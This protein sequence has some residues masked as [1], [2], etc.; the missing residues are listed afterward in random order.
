MGFI[1]VRA[2]KGPRHEFDAPEAVVA[3]SPSAYVVLDRDPVTEARP[4]RYVTRTAPE[5]RGG[6]EDGPRTKPKIEQPVAD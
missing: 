1:R 3:A 4:A 2:S 5:E 6:R